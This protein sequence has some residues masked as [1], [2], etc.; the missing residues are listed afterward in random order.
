M[1]FPG[2]VWNTVYGQRRHPQIATALFDLASEWARRAMDL[3]YPDETVLDKTVRLAAIGQAGELLIKSTLAGITPV[4]LAEKTTMATLLPLAGSAR[5]AAQGKL[6]TAG[7]AESLKRLNEVRPANTPQIQEPKL[8]FDVRNGAT[9]MGL[10][11]T[12][13]DLES[14]LTELVTLAD[15]VFKVRNALLL[16]GDWQAFWSSK[17]IKIV[18]ARQRAHYESLVRGFNA[19]IASAQA[20][21]A[22]LI[23]GLDQNERNRVVAELVARVPLL[24]DT[25]TVRP[26]Q[27]PA[28]HNQLWVVYDVVREVDIDESDMPH[29][30]TFFVR[31]S[32]TVDYAECPV[33]N[34]VLD[35]DELAL[36]GIPF[37]LHLGED[38]A[39]EDEAEGWRDARDA[40]I[41]DRW[42]DYP[43]DD[44]DD[45]PY[46]P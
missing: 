20:A 6:T 19:L 35:G 11:P 36:T 18:E 44:P 21:Y 13:D 2:Y 30:V 39:T 7:A 37:T 12:D 29:G 43:G 27:C 26:H 3:P 41:E 28:C 25:Q 38:E 45:D 33:C 15:Q 22:R 17:H 14:A 40:E 16:D 24:E 5:K 23:A 1:T 10:A 42:D 46:E 32:A 34:L 9:H 31:I 8:L 4:L